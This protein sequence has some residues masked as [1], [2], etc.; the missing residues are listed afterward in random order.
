MLTQ[1]ARGEHGASECVERV[2]VTLAGAATV[3]F[4]ACLAGSAVKAGVLVV[5]VGH[6]GC[7]PAGQHCV[8]GGSCFGGEVSADGGHAVDTLTAQ[9]QVSAPG[10][11][12]V[13]E[14]AVGVEAIG[15]PVGELGEVVGSV[16]GREP[17]EVGLG[18]FACLDVDLRG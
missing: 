12:G 17:G 4:D 8:E 1:F 3:G 6:A 15:K 7:S 13:G 14:V 10:A 11:V 18:F 2:M 16:A 9:R 5:G